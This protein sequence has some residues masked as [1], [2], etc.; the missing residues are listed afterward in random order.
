MDVQ[1]TKLLKTVEAGFADAIKEAGDAGDPTEAA[2]LDEAAA[3]EAADAG[4]P[5]NLVLG[6][7]EL[8]KAIRLLESAPNGLTEEA[9]VELA[10][11]YAKQ[12]K[13]HAHRTVHRRAF[14]RGHRFARRVTGRTEPGMRHEYD[15]VRE[16][17][18]RR[19]DHMDRYR[20]DLIER[21]IRHNGGHVDAGIGYYYSTFQVRLSVEGTPACPAFV[22]Q[23]SPPSGAVPNPVIDT[24]FD[25]AMGETEP[26]WFGGPHTL[27]SSDTNLQTPGVYLYPN[28][29]MIIE[30][31]SAKLKAFRIQYYPVGTQSPPFPLVDPA[32]M[33]TV[34]RTLMGTVPT[35]DREG[36]LLP[37]GFFN[38]FNDNCELAQAIAMVST[39]FFA[40]NNP[41]LGGDKAL[42][43]KLVERMSAVPGVHRH[44][45]QEASGAGLHLDLPRGFAWCLDKTFQGSENSGGNGL[46][47]AQLHQTES[48]TFPFAAI[49]VAG[50]PLPVLPLGAAIEIQLTLHGT[51]LIPA[52]DRDD[53]AFRRKM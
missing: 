35:W 14:A 40:W 47:S 25:Y 11:R 48:F 29:L 2:G 8:V 10:K 17:P 18:W 46:F 23:V 36:L 50:S 41:D 37:P 51:S 22:L 4:E 32:T 42:T 12:E 53:R 30:A 34:N 1:E 19:S 44:G 6:E 7:R 3:V 38:R 26:E 33:P 31:V 16:V 15:L 52:R 28:Q 21:F 24:C 20:W 49:P 13:A 27:N 45:V 43:F 5:P 39:L 9:V